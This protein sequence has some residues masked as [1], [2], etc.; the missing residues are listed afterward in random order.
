MKGHAEQQ[1]RYGIIPFD[2]RQMKAAAMKLAVNVSL[3]TITKTVVEAAVIATIGSVSAEMLLAP[4][5]SAGIGNIGRLITGPHGK[6]I[7]RGTLWPA[8]FPLIRR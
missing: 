5:K 2:G 4:F 1:Q 3:V 6:I 8:T 7:A